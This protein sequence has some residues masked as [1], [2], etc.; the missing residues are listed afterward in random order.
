MTSLESSNIQTNLITWEAVH[1]VYIKLWSEL[2]LPRQAWL[3]WAKSSQQRNKLQPRLNT[4][5]AGST[6]THL[7]KNI[8]L[9]NENPLNSKS[10]FTKKPAFGTLFQSCSL[11]LGFFGFPVVLVGNPHRRFPFSRA[12][13][14]NAEVQTTSTASELSWNYEAVKAWIA[15][16]TSLNP[17]NVLCQ[18]PGAGRKISPGLERWPKSTSWDFLCIQLIWANMSNMS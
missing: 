14:P 17:R 10:L 15:S 7:Q 6:G 16:L 18:R 13:L 2:W 4:M 12:N 3:I 9:I 11:S 5:I 8:N 1:A